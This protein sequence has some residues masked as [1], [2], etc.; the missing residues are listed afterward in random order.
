MK[1]EEN[2]FEESQVAQE[3]IANIEN[4]ADGVRDREVYPL[5]EKWVGEIKPEVLVEIGSGQGI[6]SDKIN[7]GDGKYIGVE[8]SLGLTARAQELYNDEQREF[9][10][11]N[12]YELP[13]ANEIADAGFTV[14]VWFHLEDLPRASK[15]LARILKPDG[16][17]LIIT[18]NPDTYATWESFYFDHEKIGNKIVGK[19]NTPARPMSKNTFYQHSLQEITNA[20]NDAGLTI[21]ELFPLGNIGEN[22]NIFITIKGHK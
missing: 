17:Y 3:W 16:Q 1:Y 20:L 10:V 22:T 7:C 9:V 15:E 12:G 11:G 8:P 19:V 14:N 6:C 2:P 4:E 21:D 13:L 18:A 5:L